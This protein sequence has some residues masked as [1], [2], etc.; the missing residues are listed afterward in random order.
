MCSN[1]RASRPIP[2]ETPVIMMFLAM[3][4][5]LGFIPLKFKH[6]LFRKNFIIDFLFFQRLKQP[7]DDESNFGVA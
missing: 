3:Y 7:I 1:L 4:F 6:Y 5:K 2:E